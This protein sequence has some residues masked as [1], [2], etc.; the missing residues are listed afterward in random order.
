MREGRSLLAALLMALLF[1]A[2]TMAQSESIVILDEIEILD[3]SDLGIE[4]VAVSPDGGVVIAHGADSAV[5]IIDSA[6]PK[7]NSLIGPKGSVSLLDGSFHPGGKTVL[8]V[9]ESGAILRLTMA[10]LSIESAGGSSTFGDTELGAVS[11]NSDGSWA[12]IGGEEGWIWR[13]RGLEDGGLEAFPLEN[14]GDSDINAISCLRGSNICIVSTDFDGIGIIDEEHKLSWIGGFEHLWVDAVCNSISSF[15]CVA[16]SSDL[17]I[18]RIGVNVGDTSETTMYDNDIVQLQGFEGAMTG[19]NPQRGG[20]SLISLAPFGLIEY[21]SSVSRSFHWLDNTDVVEFDVAISG[22]RIVGTWG[23][24]PYGGWIVTD[25]GSVVSFDLTEQENGGSMLEIWIGLIIL[26][27]TTLMLLSL[28]TSSSPRL[29]RWL[30]KK[31]GSEEERKSAIREER[32][33]SRKKGRA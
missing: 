10:N 30:T 3:E 28:I 24:S 21:D 32:R 17:S 26:G 11:W 7:N 13:Y 6:S 22:E 33:L 29:S 25:R 20:N 16:I 2:L 9:G 5:F 27:G 8:L 12:Y 23:V 14:R 31:I 19:I 4:G 18:A 1:P 15:E